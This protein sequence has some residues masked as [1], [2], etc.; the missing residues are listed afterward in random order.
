[1]LSKEEI[2]NHLG[3]SIAYTGRL[4]SNKI[5]SH[6]DELGSNI[7]FEQM[8][9]LFFI[10]LYSDREIIQQDL[11]SMMN[12][13]KSAVLRTIDILEKKGYVKRLPVIGDRRKNIIEPTE[14][15]IKMIKEA[16]KLSQKLEKEYTKKISK[17]DVQTCK[18]VLEIIQNECKTEVCD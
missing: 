13:N 5:N 8:G 6:F 1:M 4:I 11:A 2:K 10:A 12:K 16:I 15:G 9:V 14:T 18:R 3:T 7:T 17:E